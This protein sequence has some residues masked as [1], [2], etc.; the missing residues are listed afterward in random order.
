MRIRLGLSQD[1]FGRRKDPRVVASAR[2]VVERARA[3]VA[4]SKNCRNSH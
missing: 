3:V 4:G 2:A 1:C